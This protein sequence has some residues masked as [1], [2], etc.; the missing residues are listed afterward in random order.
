MLT[1]SMNALLI[2]LMGTMLLIFGI[3]HAYA[4]STAETELIKQFEFMARIYAN[5]RYRLDDTFDP[6]E[7]RQILLALG[8]S[9]LSEHAQWIMMHR[10]RSVDQTEIW[11][12]GS[13]G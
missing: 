12:L 9:A 6:D 2:T 8:K 4:Y 1:S 7:K 10:E 3:R 11:R 5:A 13:G